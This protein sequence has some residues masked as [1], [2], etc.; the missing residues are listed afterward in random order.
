MLIFA[1]NL[2]DIEEIGCSSVDFYDI[3]LGTGT[4]I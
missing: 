2:Q 4:R 3:L 1:L